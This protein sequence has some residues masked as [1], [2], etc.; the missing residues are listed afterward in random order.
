MPKYY[1]VNDSSIHIQNSFFANINPHR[2]IKRFEHVNI[3][4]SD[5]LKSLFFLS[6]TRKARLIH[7]I[8]RQS[9][10]FYWTF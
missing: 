5:I 4:L 8:F 7:Q 3:I 9:L 2:R 6:I 10:I 1:Q